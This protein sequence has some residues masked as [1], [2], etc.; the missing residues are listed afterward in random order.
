MCRSLKYSIT[1]LKE[2]VFIKLIVDKSNDRVLGLHYIG[3]N[4]AEIIQGFAVAIVNGLT[5]KQF[6]KT[7]GIHPTCAEEIVTLK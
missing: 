1:K 4:A 3:E 7:I 5:K 2:K 6:D